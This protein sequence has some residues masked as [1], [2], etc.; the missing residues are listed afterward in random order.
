MLETRHKEGIPQHGLLSQRSA[1]ESRG[2]RSW[3]P[4]GQMRR[5]QVEETRTSCMVVCGPTGSNV[6]PGS[7]N[8]SL[9]PRKLFGRRKKDLRRGILR[10]TPRGEPRTS[11]RNQGHGGREEE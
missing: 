4:D 1:P 7:S 6:A 10:R 8:Q 11:L 2:V 5:V 9:I 3:A